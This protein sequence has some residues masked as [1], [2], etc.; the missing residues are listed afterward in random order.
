M[1][2][3]GIIFVFIIFIIGVV[4]SARNIIVKNGVSVGIKAI[5]GLKLEMESLKIGL[6]DTSIDINN[7]KIFNPQEYSDRVMLDMPDIYIDYNLGDFFKK[8]VHLEEVR[9]NLKELVVIKNKKGEL[10]LNALNVISDKKEEK[11]DKDKKKKEMPELKI[12]L[13][14]L[15]IGKVIYKDYSKSDVPSIKEFNINIEETFKDVLNAKALVRIILTKALMKS[16][17]SGLINLDL[18]DL[19]NGALGVIKGGTDLLKGTANI[20]TQVVEDLG[21]TTIDTLKDTSEGLKKL[22]PFGK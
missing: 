21:K 18:G 9:L 17:I 7:L 15:K 6:V 8:K 5:T 1:K 13:L 11:T 20:T 10:N 2:K 4:V 14:K 16:G 22:L 19:T 3:V 12:D